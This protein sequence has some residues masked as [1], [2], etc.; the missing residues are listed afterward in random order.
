[1]KKQNRID[2]VISHMKEEGLPQMIVTSTPS[3]YYLTGL[4]IDPHERMLALYLDTEGRLVLCGNELFAVDGNQCDFECLMHSD[5]EDPIRDLAK[6]VKPGVIGVDKFWTANFLLPLLS[7]RRDLIPK[8]GSNPVDEARMLKDEEEIRLMRRAC[9]VNDKAMAAVIGQLREGVSEIQLASFLQETYLE[10]GADFP[11][12]VQL[13]CFGANAAD[14]HHEPDR[15]TLKAGDCALLDIF[16]PV[17]RYWCDMTRTVYFQSVD[18]QQEK[19]YQLVRQANQA[20]IDLIRPSVPLSQIDAAARDI[21]TQAGYGPHFFHRLGHGCGIECHEP[22]NCSAAS[23]MVARPGMIFS[24]EPGIY[25]EGKYG[26][27]IEDLVLVT[28]SG[29]EVLGAYPK[30]MQ[31]IA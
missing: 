23:E 5:T 11:I 26:V 27:R 4:W 15:T 6:V 7:Q 29:C 17:N 14:P 24:V 22:P 3:V 12:G 2:R 19:I 8:L 13:V 16:T 31:V 10:L 9:Q 18:I 20:A 21:I 25:L 1:M 28:E 30:R